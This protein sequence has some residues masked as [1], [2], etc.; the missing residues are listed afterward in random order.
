VL[1]C[2]WELEDA[3]EW[4]EDIREL[5]LADEDGTLSITV[6]RANDGCW[7]T[8]SAGACVSGRDSK[9][10]S[11]FYAKYV[12]ETEDTLLA[13]NV[14]YG[15]LVIKAY[16]YPKNGNPSYFTREFFSRKDTTGVGSPRDWG[17]IPITPVAKACNLG[18]G[19]DFTAAA[20]SGFMEMVL[21][22]N[23]NQGIIIIASY[24]IFQDATGRSSYFRRAFFFR[25]ASIS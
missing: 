13:A 5:E 10:V 25:E 17:E 14:K 16:H 24:N 22:A 23:D 18:P 21:S 11:G 7:G 8:T 15:I 1:L 19:Q 9:E 20:T 3:K 2:W 12:R 4:T 6:Q